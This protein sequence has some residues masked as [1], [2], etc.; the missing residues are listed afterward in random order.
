MKTKRVRKCI[1]GELHE[2]YTLEKVD[3][4]VSNHP[5]IIR[6]RDFPIGFIAQENNV[7]LLVWIPLKMD[8]VDIKPERL[9]EKDAVKKA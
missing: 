5:W 4:D 9:S 3:E 6:F 1:K 7:D 2:L 8:L